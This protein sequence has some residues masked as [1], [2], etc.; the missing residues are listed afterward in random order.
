[1]DLHKITLRDLQEWSKTDPK[2]RLRSGTIELRDKWNAGSKDPSKFYSQ[3]A[4]DSYIYDLTSWHGSGSVN[5]WFDT[6]RDL[7]LKFV[8]DHGKV[9]DFGSGIGTYSI[10]AYSL[11]FVVT[12]CEVNK[13]LQEYSKWRFSRHN[14]GDIK[15]VEVPDTTYDAI[16]CVDTIEHLSDPNA[17]PKYATG[18]LNPDGILIATWTFHQS[19][20]MHPMHPGPE[21]ADSFTTALRNVFRPV[22]DTW[23]MAFKRYTSELI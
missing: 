6:V 23:P 5:P 8:P 21:H 4:G 13:E 7:L 2:D 10:M 14:M 22:S 17:F 9:L 20:G 11:G 12:A 3:E 15:I 1:M 18:I 19:N 16:I